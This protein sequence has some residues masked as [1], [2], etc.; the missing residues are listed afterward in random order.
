MISDRQKMWKYTL[1]G[2]A[3]TLFASG[4]RNTEKYRLRP[5]TEEIWGCDH[6]SDNFGA[7]LKEKAG[8]NQPV[9]DF[10]P[11]CELNHYVEGGFYGHPFVVGN[12]QIREEYK[13]RSDILDLAAKTIVP[14]WCFGAHWAPNGWCF[15]DPAINDRTHAFPKDH[16]GDMFVAFHGSWNRSEPAG[17]CVARVLFDQG[18]PYGLLK[19]VSTMAPKGQI[20]AR[21]VDCVQAPDGSILWSSDFKGRVYRIRHSAEGP[22]K[23]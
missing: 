5:G 13:D 21:P 1:D 19:I 8:S 2:K 11:P 9:T 12:R 18:H 16:D 22:Q 4:I 10:N 15:I 23:N 20:V 14:E 7:Y 3:K 17:Y 6:G